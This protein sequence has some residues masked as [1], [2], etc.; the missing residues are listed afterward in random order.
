[1]QKQGN[2]ALRTGLKHRK[3]FYFREAVTAYT[4]GLEEHSSDSSIETLIYSN[5]A[6]VHLLLGNNRSALEDGLA[7][8]KLED[9]NQKVTIL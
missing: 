4:K 1:M 5:R 7:A 3:K 2:E 6:Q 8:L 9:Q